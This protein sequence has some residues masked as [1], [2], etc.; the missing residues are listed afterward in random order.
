MG[1]TRFGKLTRL[2]VAGE[3]A[4]V[5]C[6]CGVVKTVRNRDME[7]GRI[8]SCGCSARGKHGQAA[9]ET[10]TREYSRWV[11]MRK[12][13]RHH[14]RYA[15]RGIKVCERWN[16]FANFYAD[17]GPVPEGQTLER[18]DNDG[19]YEPGNCRWASLT[20]QQRNTS[21]T[22]WVVA[23]G[24][25]APLAEWSKRTGISCTTIWERIRKGWPAERALRENTQ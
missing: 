23:F 5:R 21:R 11:H 6:D 2:A 15:G 9:R 8:K 17:M 3:R 16:D 19:D 14:E 24:T 25:R 10:Q 7:R 18:I 22:R 4:T 1:G 12:R 20:E 13:C